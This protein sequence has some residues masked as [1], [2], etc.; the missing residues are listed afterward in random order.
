MLMQQQQQQQQERAPLRLHN[1]FTLRVGQVFTGFGVGCGIG[2]GVGR[3]INLR[4]VP[5]LG[6]V[7]GESIGYFRSWK[8]H[9]DSLGKK[10]GVKNI[11]AGVGCGIGVGHGFG[12]GITL[13]P[14]TVQELKHLMEQAFHSV[15][16]RL[17]SFSGSSGSDEGISNK[18]RTL[19][20][21]EGKTL[22]DIL[23]P[24]GLAS[25]QSLGS[26]VQSYSL[27]ATKGQFTQEPTH[28]EVSLKL[29]A[30][31]LLSKY[32]VKVFT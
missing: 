11:Q 24:K 4:A 20:V 14:G 28:G 3:S 29:G 23:S 15:N 9:V 26:S 16:E 5:V 22:P 30:F 17:K 31:L 25:I 2:I 8:P 27:N 6:S 7:A 13:K 10:L 21:S 12:I 32:I 1:P 18:E 19:T